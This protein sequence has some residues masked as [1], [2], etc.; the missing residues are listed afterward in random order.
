MHIKCKNT[1]NQSI[2]FNLQQINTETMSVYEVHK[3]IKFSCGKKKHHP[4]NW[5]MFVHHREVA[6]NP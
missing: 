4:M 1:E 2:I 3:T 5:Q 6:L